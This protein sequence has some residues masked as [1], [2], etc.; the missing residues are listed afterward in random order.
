MLAWPAD[1]SV[2]GA[3][4]APILVGCCREVAPRSADSA[5]GCHEITV[6]TIVVT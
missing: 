5:L 6:T 2:W 1:P 3:Q 4:P